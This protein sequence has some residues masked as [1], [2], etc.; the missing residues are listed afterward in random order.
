MQTT[1]EP[2]TGT[3]KNEAG[4]DVELG[5]PHQK[6]PT[7]HDKKRAEKIDM[8]PGEPARPYSGGETQRRE[9]A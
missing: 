7:E 9:T 8:N 2:I 4:Q 1:T 5:R 3:V 6:L